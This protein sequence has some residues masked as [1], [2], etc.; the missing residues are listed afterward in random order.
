MQMFQ[1]AIIAVGDAERDAGLLRY[2]RLLPAISPGIQCQ[3][4]HVLNWAGRNRSSDPQPTHKQ[5]R[6]RLTA[7]VGKNFGGE[8]AFCR[9]LTGEVVDQLLETVAE[10]AAD[11]ILVGHAFEH[12]GRRALARR[13]AMKAP[14]CVWM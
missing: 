2:A 13:L 14:C 11:L 3:F 6:E 1:R 4:V 12:S 5:A 9:V 7:A 10:S 8:D